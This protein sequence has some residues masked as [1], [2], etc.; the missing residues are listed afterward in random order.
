MRSFLVA[1]A[2]LTIVPVRFRTMPD[3]AT[4][5]R[6]RFWYPVVAALLGGALGGWT[7][8]LALWG[9]P[10]LVSAF[11][12]LLAWVILTGTLHL[13][14]FCD[15]CDGL[16]GGHTPE[17]RLRIMKDPHVGTFGLA[18]GVLLLLGKFVLLSEVVRRSDGPWVVGGAVVVAR[19][20]ALCMAAM[21]RYPRPEGT[22]KALI[23]AA[24]PWE[25]GLFLALAGAAMV[26]VQ[27]GT[28]QPGSWIWP[29]PALAGVSLLIWVCH[30]RLGGVTGDCLGAA[31]E[32]AEMLFLFGAVAAVPREGLR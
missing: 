2:F 1:L 23:D 20:L 15:L 26:A 25:A 7:A 31:I 16:F 9:R 8:L 27:F 5:A 12:I 4:V 21:S 13:D 24:R 30:R 19:C 22:G 11:L 28:C 17:D 10:P 3:A 32:A 6:S 18:G 14:G 29:L